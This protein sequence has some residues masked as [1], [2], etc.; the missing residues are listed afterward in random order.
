MFKYI[1]CLIIIVTVVV[2]TFLVGWCMGYDYG[3]ENGSD[4]AKKVSEIKK[5]VEA[6]YKLEWDNKDPFMSHNGA[7]FKVYEVLE[8]IE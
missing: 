6:D 4:A 2:A 7:F 3:A 5:I 1:I 8:G